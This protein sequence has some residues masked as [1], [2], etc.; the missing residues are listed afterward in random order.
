LVPLVYKTQHELLS[1]LF[2]SLT[3]AFILIALV[4]MFVLKNPGA[5]LLSMI[6]NV[7]PVVM[8]F[9]IMGWMGILV[10]VGSMM[11]ASVALGVAVDDTMHYLTWFR[12]GLDEG[13]DREGAAMLA[14]RRCGTAMTQTTLIGGLGLAAF[15][16][17][18][19]TPTQRFGTLMLVLLF[20]A[21]F[22]DLVFLPAILTGPLGRVF[23][24]GK[25]RKR[26]DSRL[27]DDARSTETVED[28]AT[29]PQGQHPATTPHARR[30]SAH[31]PRRAP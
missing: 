11:T 29:A 1:G 4:M 27:D 10:D 31:H 16:F 18:T 23:G 17:S 28:G 6:P 21:L 30:D 22:G 14:Y 12:Q 26:P 19:F 9:G 13:L 7:F 25:K 8:I 15:A 2:K 20:A 3:M 24:G 5:G